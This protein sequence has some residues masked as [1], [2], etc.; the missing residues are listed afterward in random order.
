ML[1]IIHWLDWGYIWYCT[2]DLIIH[3]VKASLLRLFRASFGKRPV[4]KIRHYVI[5]FI[6]GLL[7]DHCVTKKWITADTIC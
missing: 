5:A 3:Y 4:N 7:W 6:L 2:S 1:L